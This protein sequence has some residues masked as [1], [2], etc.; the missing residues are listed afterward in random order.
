MLNITDSFSQALFV[1]FKLFLEQTSAF[2]LN[3]FNW[4]IYFI[5]MRWDFW[6]EINEFQ[7]WKLSHDFPSYLLFH[8]IISALFLFLSL[9]I[10]SGERFDVQA[11]SSSK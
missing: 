9:W 4:L 8:Y 2:S 10:I 3:I 1:A 7:I 11:C 6:I 5:E